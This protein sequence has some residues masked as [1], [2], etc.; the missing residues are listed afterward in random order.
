MLW[1]TRSRIIDFYRARGRRSQLLSDE[2]LEQYSQRLVE[3]HDGN[4][5]RSEA[6]QSCLEQLPDRSRSLIRLKYHDGLKTDQI[7]QSL[8]ST[9]ASVRVALFRIREALAACIQRKLAPEAVE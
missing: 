2:L 8:K 4:S 7:A 5:R 9:P 3:Q 6:L 1:L